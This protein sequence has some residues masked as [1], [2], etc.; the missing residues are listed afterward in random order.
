MPNPHE[1]VDDGIVTIRYYALT[2]SGIAPAAAPRSKQTKVADEIHW[3]FVVKPNSVAPVMDVRTS[4][5]THDLDTIYPTADFIEQWVEG[6]NRC[7]QAF[8]AQA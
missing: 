7:G 3:G 6:R 5:S 1:D 2:G 4:N 8:R